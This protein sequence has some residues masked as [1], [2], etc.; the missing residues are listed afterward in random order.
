MT[1]KLFV[2]IDSKYHR[3]KFDDYL[4]GGKIEYKEKAYYWYAQDS[5][6]GF[7]WEVEPIT[8]VD[9]SSL[10]ENEFIEVMRIIEKCLY[11]HK[12][13]YEVGYP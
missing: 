12:T 13:E 5:N 1:D 7:G 4:A 10:D 11:E 3:S 9:W 8:E 2:T 6:Y